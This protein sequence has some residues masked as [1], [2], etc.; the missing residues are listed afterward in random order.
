MATLNLEIALTQNI[1]DSIIKAKS[2]VQSYDSMEEQ[3]SFGEIPFGFNTN[4]KL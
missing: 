1:Y 3:H 4:N 2:R